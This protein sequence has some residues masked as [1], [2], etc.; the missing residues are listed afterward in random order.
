MAELEFIQ[1]DGSD[2]RNKRKKK[3]EAIRVH[4]MKNFHRQRRQEAAKR[5]FSRACE[6][7]DGWSQGTVG[8]TNTSSMANEDASQQVLR[9]S[10]QPGHGARDQGARDLPNYPFLA[11][12]HAD[13][14]LLPASHTHALIDQ[15][16][17][18][19]GLTVDIVGLT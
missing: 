8:V 17:L 15:R 6:A 9:A 1:F 19:H 13:R 2:D 14:S 5:K 18:I 10:I 16:R 11:N 12:L 4:V 3:R 7:W